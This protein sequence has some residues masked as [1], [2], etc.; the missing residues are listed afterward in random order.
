MFDVEIQTADALAAQCNVADNTRGLLDLTRMI[1]GTLE[2][3]REA[4]FA[5]PYR[6]A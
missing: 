5:E 2:S 6:P 4:K 1:A 3:G